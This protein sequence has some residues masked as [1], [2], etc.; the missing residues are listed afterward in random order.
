[1]YDFRDIHYGIMIVLSEWKQQRMTYITNKRTGAT[2]SEKVYLAALC[3]P[4]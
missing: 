2:L 1:M 3:N 4:F